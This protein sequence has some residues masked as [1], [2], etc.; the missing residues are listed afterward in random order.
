MEEKDL[1]GTGRPDRR[2]PKLNAACHEDVGPVFLDMSPAELVLAVRDP[3]D[4]K[5]LPVMG[6]ARKLDIGARAA[7][8]FEVGRA[9]VQ[10]D[11][12]Q[13]AGRVAQ[14]IGDG[15]PVPGMGVVASGQ[16]N[17]VV[18]LHDHVLQQPDPG[19]LEEI[20]PPAA[21]P[22]VIP[23]DRVNPVL[24]VK[25][26]ELS[27]EL[28][29]VLVPPVAFQDIPPDED[30]IGGCGVDFSDEPLQETA[31]RDRPEM[32]IGGESDRQLLCGRGSSGNLDGVFPNSEVVIIGDSGGDDQGRDDQGG[33]E[34]EAPEKGTAN[35]LAGE[36]IE[37]A[38]RGDREIGQDDGQ[39]KIQEQR[40]GVVSGD[41]DE[42]CQAAGPAV[43]KGFRDR[44][45]REEDDEASR[46]KD[47]GD[48]PREQP[49]DADVRVDGER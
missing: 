13:V 6:M 18:D 47:P 33:G 4:G 39:D 1:R 14:E 25:T 34:P 30:N 42:L 3:V 21:M 45:T 11:H 19:P 2:A 22:F 7:D 46:E 9:M 28:A 10:K 16:I 24:R 27:L 23:R 8:I 31:G 35:R 37:Q 41:H 36:D 32:E 5:E 17:R 40:Q 48:V 12:R 49:Q 26:P 38:G 29:G 43:G 20:R 15:L 44:K